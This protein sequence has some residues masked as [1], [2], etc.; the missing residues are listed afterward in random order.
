MTKL[1]LKNQLWRHFSDVIVITWLKNVSISGY[2][3]VWVVLLHCLRDDFDLFCP[4]ITNRTSRK[5]LPNTFN[6]RLSLSRDSFLSSPINNPPMKWISFL[7][8]FFYDLKVSV[9][10][11]SILWLL[12]F[13][14]I[15][16]NK[17]QEDNL[18]QPKIFTARLSAIT[19][20]QLE[21]NLKKLKPIKTLLQI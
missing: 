12:Q 7:F 6:L 10:S 4:E 1:N 3:M 11:F 20:K 13:I 17:N 15:T 19:Q 14:N 21:L 5:K 18:H 9:L 2:A 8:V 16:N